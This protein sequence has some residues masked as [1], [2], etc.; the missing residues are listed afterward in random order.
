MQSFFFLPIFFVR[1]LS[2]GQE[3]SERFRLEKQTSVVKRSLDPI[4]DEEFML[5][6]RRCGVRQYCIFFQGG[7]FLEGTVWCIDVDATV[8]CI[9]VDATVWC[10]DM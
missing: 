9:D 2:H 8:W 5:P 6:V 3:W 4:W 1:Y 7:V 10:I